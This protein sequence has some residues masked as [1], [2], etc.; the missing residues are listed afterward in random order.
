[1][2]PTVRDKT[3]VSTTWQ[4]ALVDE[5]ANGTVGTASL[6]RTG[7][8]RLDAKSLDKVLDQQKLVITRAQ[9]L[10]LG[11]SASDL[12]RR[13]QADG[14]WQRILPGVYLAVTGTP[15]PDQRDIAALLYAG[16]GS[17]LT[18]TSALRH[19]G[20]SAPSTG[21]LDVIVPAPRQRQ[22]AGFVVIHRTFRLPDQV[23]YQGPLQFALPAR[24][25]ADAA[26]MT[27]DLAKVR[28]VVAW[29]VQ[30]RRCTV[31]QLVD[32]LWSGPVQ[33]SA[34]LRTAL[35]EV[36]RGVRSVPEADL[37]SLIVRGELPMPLFNPR[38]F[39][40][41]KLLAVP[42]AWW[43][44]TGLIVEVDSREWHL[45]P[46]S[47]E[48]TMRRHARLTALGILVLHFS[49]RHIRDEPGEVL[50]TIRAALSSRGGRFSAPIRTVPASA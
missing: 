47:W 32:E 37:M 42:D 23:C 29:A 33:G 39:L 44:D 26:R 43:P 13:A 24:A 21:V 34:L 17:T 9:A 7:R 20:L 28:A 31:D 5:I 27:D 3:T 30:T 18:G 38:L 12:H 25:V 19:H 8:R 14:R 15:T 22:N 50:D 10:A 46:Q 16:H 6:A 11:V 41:D 4:P 49:P 36:A 1:M 40:G 2:S 45:S 35:S 48:Q